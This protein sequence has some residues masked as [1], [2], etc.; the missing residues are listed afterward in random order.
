M[1]LGVCRTFLLIAS[2]TSLLSG[3]LFTNVKELLLHITDALHVFTYKYLNLNNVY[4][5]THS[6]GFFTREHSTIKAN[7]RMNTVVVML[8][9]KAET[10]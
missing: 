10:S 5:C 7:L 1:L 3:S 2:T 9:A 6:E 4:V 8:H